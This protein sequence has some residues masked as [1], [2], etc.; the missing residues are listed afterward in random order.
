MKKHIPLLIVFCIVSMVF[1]QNAFAQGCV[2]IRPMSGCAGISAGSAALSKGQWQVGANYRYFKSF[3][4]YRGDSEQVERLEQNTEVINHAHSLDLGVSYGLT[5]RLSVAVN[6]PFISYDRSSLYEHYG[7][8][9]SA[10]PEHKRFNTSAKGIGD[11]RISGSYW[12]LNPET[13]LK[14]NLAVGIGIKLPTGNANVQDEFHKR[15]SSDG[16]DSIV[17]KAVDQSIQLGDGGVGISLELQAFTSVFENGTLYFNGFYMSNPQEVNK[18]VNRP[19]TATTTDIQKIT[20]FHSVA[21]QY[22][23]R[24]GLNYTVLP[25][26]GFAVNLGVRAEGIPAKDLIGGSN[27]F[28][29]PGYIVSAEPGLSYQHGRAS[30]SLNV[31]YALYR[32]RV[33]SVSDLADPTGQAHG[34]AAFADY[35]INVGAAWRFGGHHAAAMNTTVPQFKN[36]TN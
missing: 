6:L 25:S 29:R 15:K 27:G 30:F 18:T 19:I 10:N 31:P 28:R 4:H 1:S 16:T 26:H 33:K 22:V 20:A 5:N 12:L 35:S 9:A 24:L 2:A 36:V 11:L 14:S 23:A 21:D 17:V 13:H 34:D 8:S 3:R 32:N 7:N